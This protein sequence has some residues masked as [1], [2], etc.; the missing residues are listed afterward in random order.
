MTA[1]K[2]VRNALD[3]PIQNQALALVKETNR[4][5]FIGKM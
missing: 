3:I 2:L 5:E 1:T 4:H